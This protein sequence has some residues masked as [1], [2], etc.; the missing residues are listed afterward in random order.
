M[1]SGFIVGRLSRS[2][3][4]VFLACLALCASPHVRAA[5]SV[6]EFKARVTEAAGD[7]R[8]FKAVGTVTEKNK[9]ALE[10]LNSE[11]ARL[12][13]FDKAYISLKQPDK[14]RMDGKLGMVKMTYII[15]GWKKIFRAAKVGISKVSDYSGDPAKLQDAFDIGLITPSM[16][17]HRT[18]QIIEDEQARQNGE[19]KLLLKWPKGDML[20]Y[21][22]VDAENLWLKKFEKRDSE[23]NLQVRI[24]YSEPQ[25]AGGV[26]WMPM[27][28]EVYTPDGE[29]AVTSV[30][31]DVEVNTGLQ[32]SVFE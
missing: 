25:K 17:R 16:W 27:K 10:S 3:T 4:P 14:L 9:K 13:E 23:G 21:A 6:E 15:N 1:I 30:Y 2:L 7:F 31:S 22:W 28:T 29:K 32:D 18:I 5:C 26:I 8:D 24:V 19:I 12:Y 11:Y 20:N